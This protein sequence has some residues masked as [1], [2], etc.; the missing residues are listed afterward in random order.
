M[1]RNIF[2]LILFTFTASAQKMQLRPVDTKTDASFRGLSVI[3]DSVAWVSGSKGWI[4]ITVDGGKDWSFRQVKGFEQCDFRSI[5]AFNAK[6]A[7]IAN[8]GSP[9]YILCTS[10]G[11]NTWQKVYENN[12]SAAFID[13]VDFWNHKNGIVY[14]DPVSGR[15]LLVGTNDGG[16]SWTE[17]PPS[18]RSAMNTGEASFAA[19]G[20]C[21]RCRQRRK[22]VIAT[23]GTVSRLLVSKN[24]G[25]SWKAL[26][27]PILQGTASTGTFTFLPLGKKL[28][29]IAGGDYQHDS[30]STANLFVTYDAGKTWHAPA[31]TTRGYRECLEVIEHNDVPKVRTS[32]LT[33]TGTFKSANTLLAVGPGGIDIS[34][35]SGDHWIPL[36][37]EKQFHVVKK[38]RS[39]NLIIIAG[40]H[41]KVAVLK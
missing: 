23:G 26:P 17:Y 35:D 25:R 28:W 11:G 3:N 38:S 1:L 18:Q 22:L 40:G 32:G 34:Y 33:E 36:S 16:N 8:A 19:S 20:T 4:G 41:G 2:F 39:G 9:A 31:S 7:V 15:M 29:V 6:R 5:Y 37:D 21:I 13:G 10:D 24:R 30:L 12:D 14:G 27:T